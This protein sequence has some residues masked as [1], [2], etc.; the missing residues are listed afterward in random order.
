MAG[1]REAENRSRSGSAAPAE[2]SSGSGSAVLSSDGLD[3][4]VLRNAADLCAGA[5]SDVDA[6]SADDPTASLQSGAM[7]A[8]RY[9]LDR[10]IGRGGMGV[11]WEATHA[12]TQRRVAIKFMVGCSR[13]RAEM[14]R[15]FLREARAASAARHPNVV[16]VLDVFE[17]DDGL[18]VMVMEL[19]AGETLRDLLARQ[20]KLSLETAASILLGVAAAVDSAHRLGIIHRDLKPENVFLRSG[21]PPLGAV[22][23]LDF[24]VAKLAVQDGQ[25]QTESL[26][27]TGSVLGT[28]CYMA[29]EQMT[30]EKDI[31]ARADVWAL[32]VILY[33]CLA[34]RRPLEGASVGKVVMRLMSDGI[35]PLPSLVADLPDDVATLVERTLSRERQ[36]RPSDMTEVSRLLAR[37]AGSVT[38]VLPTPTGARASPR[39]EQESQTPQPV[40]IAARRAPRRSAVM[41]VAAVALLLG[42][43]G[44]RMAWMASPRDPPR[45]GAPAAALLPAPSRLE[46]S[47]V[48][49]TRH[50][51]PEALDVGHSAPEAP[52]APSTSQTPV[53]A[54][55]LAPRAASPT[56]AGR[57][58]AKPVSSEPMPAASAA[59]GRA[60]RAVGTATP[61][62][63]PSIDCEP[64]YEFDAQGRKV[65]KRACL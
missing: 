23:V 49:D 10:R 54:T 13:P 64:P 7:V 33:E 38:Q 27:G 60:V 58:I 9:R 57:F 18:P 17:I 43:Q 20:G 47:A 31:D 12:V 59:S 46:T 14:R 62:P 5:I 48:Q 34:G 41:L 63:A 42:A 21:F 24:G 6:G 29:P 30:G 28:P 35:R 22:K 65:W 11:V 40:P 52:A 4:P 55:Q 56:R 39:S 50:A 16:E 26:T 53:P 32:G 44:L 37:Y 1:D 8:G 3:D 15:R 51:A 2:P 25:A 45:N 36:D 19:L 61:A